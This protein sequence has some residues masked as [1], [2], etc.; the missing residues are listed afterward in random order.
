MTREQFVELVAAGE[1]P[2]VE[3]KNARARGDNNLVEIVRA[4]IGMANRR[5]GGLILIGV[6][7]SGNIA[8]L[9]EA[10]V[11]S[12]E[13]ADHVRQSIAPYVDPHAYVDV[14][15][16]S[17]AEGVQ[18]KRCV[19]LRVYEFDQVPVL[20]A[21]GANDARGHEV[22]RLGACYVRSR[23]LPSTTEI[24]DHADGLRLCRLAVCDPAAA[25]F[26]QQDVL[27][28]PGFALHRVLRAVRQLQSFRGDD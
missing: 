2:G 21:K 7:N 28:A 3:F 17:L 4:V 6:E 16:V 9:T 25:D 26:Q 12:W 19:V 18:A 5:D 15:V 23:Q 22:L 13:I 11:A 10:Q 24:A 8:G 14:D 1:R 27:G 20:C